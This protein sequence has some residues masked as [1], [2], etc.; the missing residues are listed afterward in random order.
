MPKRNVL[1]WTTITSGMA[2][3]TNPEYSFT[4]CMEPGWFT[5]ASFPIS[6]SWFPLAC[7]NLAVPKHPKVICENI[8]GIWFQPEHYPEQ[9]FYTEYRKPEDVRQ[10]FDKMAER[11]AFSWNIS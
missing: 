9:H 7:V 11:D 2:F 6:S 10:L 4:K 8:L 5:F 3:L 1:S